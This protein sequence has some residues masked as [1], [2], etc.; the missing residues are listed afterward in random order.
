MPTTDKDTA[1]T[2]VAR[3]SCTNK[4]SEYVSVYLNVLKQ[5][6][7][8][9]IDPN[10]QNQKGETALHHA[11]FRGSV[12]AVQFLVSLAE[13]K[14]VRRT[15]S[16]Q[17]VDKKIGRGMPVMLIGQ[18]I[19]PESN[20]VPSLPVKQVNLNVTTNTGETA[21]HYAAKA[22]HMSIVVL[23]AKHFA[24]L[25]VPSEQGLPSRIAATFNQFA[26]AS[27]LDKVIQDEQKYLPN[28]MW[29]H[30]FQYLRPRD[31][32]TIASVCKQFCRLASDNEIW[33]LKCEQSHIFRK[34]STF[35]KKIW[36]DNFLILKQFK[37]TKIPALK[38]ETNKIIKCQ[39][40]CKG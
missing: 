20:D 8:K 11:A 15:T 30:V 21:L 17:S 25:T 5:M 22:G 4:G 16:S 28:Q 19:Q 10:S 38:S 9:G 1:F 32:C 36:R 34:K 35:W 7:E 2:F 13:S 6:I 39:A 27:F 24:N 18:A 23:L 14:S 26:I 29:L 12:E 40:I 3:S 37:R 31:L 33:K